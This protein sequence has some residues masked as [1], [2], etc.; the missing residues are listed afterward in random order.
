MKESAPALKI[1]FTGRP[2]GDINFAFDQP[3]IVNVTSLDGKSHPISL[4]IQR[5]LLGLLDLFARL[6]QDGRYREKPLIK[7]ILFGISLVIFAFLGRKIFPLFVLLLNSISNA[8]LLLP[9]LTLILYYQRRA[10]R[11][12][13][14][15]LI[16]GWRLTR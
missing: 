9:M 4:V 6:F 5:V 12:L 14:L 10:L 15:W 8:W 11:S 7:L 2:H 1:I 3:H 16:S 13:K